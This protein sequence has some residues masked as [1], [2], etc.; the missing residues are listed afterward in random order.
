MIPKADVVAWREFAPWIEDVQVEQDL[1]ISRS[2]V[3]IFQNE[4]FGELLAFRGGTALYK[5]FLSPPKR[6]SE[7][8]D[9]VQ[10]NPGPIGPVFDLLRRTLGPFLGEPRRKQGPGVVTL[11][12]RVETD[13]PPV[14]PIRIKI[15]INAREHFSIF[16]YNR[17]P[18]EVR[19]RW[20]SGQC[21]A[22]TF[23][24]EELLGSKM[25]ALFQRRRGRDLF[26]LWMGLTAGKA[27][28]G[29]IIHAFGRFL[30]QDG[31]RV[32][33]DAFL[34]NLDDKLLNPVFASD[35]R[36][37]IPSGFTFDFEAAAALVRE[38][39]LEKLQ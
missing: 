6:Y 36:S 15:E 19:S 20:F 26:D 37:L 32:T 25:R 33:R 28:A 4:S 14:L 16:G 13:G 22:T 10:T 12:F 3:E 9:F 11:T 23:S 8:L 1:L 29:K 39:L 24:L 17:R 7:D 2:I 18:F 30:Q 38:N 35:I 34:R 27:D 5:L 31:L 21:R